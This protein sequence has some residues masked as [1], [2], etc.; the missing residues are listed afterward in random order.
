MFLFNDLTDPVFDG[1]GLAGFKGLIFVFLLV[2][3]I[4]PFLSS[5]VFN[6]SFLS[7]VFYGIVGLGSSD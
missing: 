6:F 2:Y 1:V 4:A 5:T 3:I 7:L